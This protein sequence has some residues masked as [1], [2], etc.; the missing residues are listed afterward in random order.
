[1]SVAVRNPGSWTQRFL[2]WV[3]TVALGL[4]L[5]WLI[6]FV[7]GDIGTWPGPDYQALEREMIEPR[8]L[9]ESLSLTQQLEE[10]RRT[11]E[12]ESS[13]QKV[14]SDSTAEAQRTMSQLLDFQRLAIEKGVTPTAEEQ[15]ALAESQSLFLSNQRQYQELNQQI[16]LLENQRNSLEEQQRRLEQELALARDP[17]QKEFDLQ[18]Q[19]H[20]WRV[21]AAK[22]G[23]MIP[24]LIVSSVLFLKWRTSL[25]AL[26]IYAFGAAVVLRT[27]Q[28]MHEYFPERWFKYILIGVSLIVVLRALVYL[29]RSIAHP[30]VDTLVR[31]YREAYERFLCPIC[32]YPIRRGPL[33]YL[34]WT[35][36][37]AKNLPQ[38]P[39]ANPERETPY[40]CPMCATRLFEEC[41]HCH[42]V[43]HAL[44]P[45]CEHCGQTHPI[46]APASAQ[47]A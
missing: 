10:T 24:L 23:V 14:L 2:V 26:L 21:A 11:I 28:V 29:V 42:A 33:K 9:S 40:T 47:L 5:F 3:F 39:L 34:V 38:Q 18:W 20:R 31:Q 6:G 37:S 32:E 22:L 17:V 45:A 43:R 30:K 7:L 46:E 19:T 13:R 27:T 8:L 12:R 1:M 41:P 16:G 35:R 15:Q 25:Y 36:R 44:L 4:L